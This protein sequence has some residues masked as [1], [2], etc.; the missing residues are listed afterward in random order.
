LFIKTQVTANSYKFTGKP[1]P[2]A[3]F[4]EELSDFLE[5]VP[6]DKILEIALDY[7]ANDTEVKEFIASIQSEEFP[8]IH[9][10]VEDLK[11]YKDVS[12]FM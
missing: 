4:Q 2:I 9:K 7:V 10:I 11:K 5:L 12:A 1:L 3:K 8:K 6:T